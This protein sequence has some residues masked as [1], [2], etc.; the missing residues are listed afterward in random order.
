MFHNPPPPSSY[1]TY[2]DT[3]ISLSGK[4][5]TCMHFLIYLPAAHPVTSFAGEFIEHRVFNEQCQRTH[6]P[7]EGHVGLR[8]RAQVLNPN[9]DMKKH[10]FKIDDGK[11]AVFKNKYNICGLVLAYV[12]FS[13]S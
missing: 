8:L 9:K 12:R 6:A 13:C 4:S 1:C 10:V 7:G 2:S 3:K 11:R 5:D